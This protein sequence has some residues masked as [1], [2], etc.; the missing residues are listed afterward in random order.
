[1]AEL[2]T[3]RSENY[4]QGIFADFVI[5]MFLWTNSQ[6]VLH[7]LRGSSKIWKP[8]IANRK[9]QVQALTLP[10]CSGHCSGSYYTADLTTREKS[11]GKILSCSLW[12]SEPA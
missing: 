4:L 7:W 10:E 5:Q 1:M 8:F 11:A 6:I 9:A 2:L 3:E 12:W